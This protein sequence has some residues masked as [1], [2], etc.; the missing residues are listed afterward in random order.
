M[1]ERP[2]QLGHFPRR[3]VD[4]DDVTSSDGLLRERV[5]HFLSQIVNS[6][7]VG[8]FHSQFSRF[9]SG[10]CRRT[11]DLDFDNFTFDEL[12]F[13]FDANSNASAKRLK[14]TNDKQWME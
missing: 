9:P 5:D 4:G 1:S 11:I 14:K 3:L 13:F 12:G 6:F 10:S 2:S 8:R 7:H